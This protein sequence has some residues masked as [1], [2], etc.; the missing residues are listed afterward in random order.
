MRELLNGPLPGEEAHLRMTSYKRPSAEEAVKQEPNPRYGSVLVP[1]Y[2]HEDEMYTSLMLRS[3]YAGVHSAQV[4]FPGGKKEGEETPEQTALRESHEELGILPQQV[5]VLGTLSPI[6]IPPSRFLVTPIVGVA[7]QRPSFQLDPVEVAKLIE[8]PLTKL[9][10]DKVESR[11]KI[12]LPGNQGNIIAPCFQVDEHIVWGAT[13]MIIS[14]FK[15][16]AAPTLH[17]L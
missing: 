11:Q 12:Q 15:A 1:V 17:N 14:E 6:F 5:E 13:A 3:E 2:L 16:L 4:S 10:D 7:V 8:V 9:F